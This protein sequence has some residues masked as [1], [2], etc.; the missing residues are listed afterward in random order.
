MSAELITGLSAT[1]YVAPNVY[2]SS[3]TQVN[4]IVP[5]TAGISKP[6]IHE[7]ELKR[8]RSNLRAMSA[9]MRGVKT[10]AM[11][12]TSSGFDLLVRRCRI[13]FKTAEP[14]IIGG[15]RRWHFNIHRHGQVQSGRCDVYVFR[16]SRIA[17]FKNGLY[18]IVPEKEIGD[19]L[20]VQVSLRS[21][22]S[23]WAKWVNRW[24]VIREAVNA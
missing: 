1:K 13:E 4:I 23:K 6:D 14:R 15:A 17:E 19:T 7:I 22:I 8:F 5:P 10:S 16:I 3:N 12:R 24:D 21:L 2:S 20:T 9:W 18:L 11:P